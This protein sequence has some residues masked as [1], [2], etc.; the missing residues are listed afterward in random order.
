MIPLWIVKSLSFLVQLSSY[1]Q[2][3][4]KTKLEQ[5]HVII[6]EAGPYLFDEG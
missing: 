4:R 6:F 3:E 1:V 2:S 5:T